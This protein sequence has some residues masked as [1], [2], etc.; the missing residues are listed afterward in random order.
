MG[1][2]TQKGA[3]DVPYPLLRPIPQPVP[4]PVAG[5]EK[6]MACSLPNWTSGTRPYHDTSHYDIRSR[7]QHIISHHT[8][9]LRS[10]QPFAWFFS[11]CAIQCRPVHQYSFIVCTSIRCHVSCNICDIPLI[12]LPGSSVFERR[13]ARVSS[14][15]PVRELV[16]LNVVSV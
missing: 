7:T 6:A 8:I 10:S 5:C 3:V 15:R 11:Q 2:G 13:F 9:F 12:F 4:Y 14:W 1:Q 16:P